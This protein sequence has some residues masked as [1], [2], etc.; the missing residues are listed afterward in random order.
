MAELYNKEKGGNHHPSDSFL[1]PEIFPTVWCP[2][3]GIGTAAYTLFEAIKEAD[4]LKKDMQIVSGIGCTGKIAESVRFKSYSDI[5]L[6]GA[7]QL[8][9]AGKKSENLIVI[10]INNFIYALS[11]DEAFP[12]TPFMRKSAGS[13]FELPFNI[14]GMAIYSGAD[15]VAR[16][17]PMQAGWM[18][19]S[20]IEAFS[21]TGLAVIEVISPCL[22]YEANSGR[23]L[24]A[25][26]RIKFYN[27]NSEINFWA[28]GK[29][30]DIRLQ[31]K[32]I[33]GKFKIPEDID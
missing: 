3:C 16:W 10:F 21:V 7:E 31:K 9:E 30:L 6:S 12:L 22:I 26:D 2:G 25:V 14:P 28:K 15:F 8:I 29:N 1:H 18:K 24:D 5:L 17:T 11:K 32:I 33:T 23:I 20:F 27:D 13:K 19:D 4:I